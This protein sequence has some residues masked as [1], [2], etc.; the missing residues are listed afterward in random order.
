MLIVA[1]SG[2]L[3]ASVRRYTTACQGCGT[4]VFLL[5]HLCGCQMPLGVNVLKMVFN[6]ELL[7][8]HYSG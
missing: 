1:V 8:Q 7:M 3:A 4:S 5:C 2:R 6:Q